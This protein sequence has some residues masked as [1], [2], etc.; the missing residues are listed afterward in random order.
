MTLYPRNSSPALDPELFRNPTSEYRGT[1]FWAWNGPLNRATL[2]RQ[3]GVLKAMGMGGYHIHVRTGLTIPYLG[4]EFMGFIRD[5]VEWAGEE[6]MLAWLYDEDR[7]PSGFAGGLV[8]RDVQY[9][10]RHLLF[11]PF[12][13]GQGETGGE[14]DSSSRVTRRTGNGALLARYSVTLKNGYLDSYH[15]LDEGDTV[16]EG[17]TTWYAYLET[18]APNPW[19]NNQT[20]VDTLNRKAI[21]RFISITHERY[22]EVVGSAFGSIIPA[23]FT[24]EPQFTHK[25]SLRFAEE[26]R[27]LVLPWTDDFLETY[28]QAYHQ[29]LEQYLPEVVW[30]L[31]G[32][33]ASLA[34]YR[35]HDHVAER[36]AQAFADTIG[37]WCNAHNLMLTGHMMEE[38]TLQ[39]QTAALGDAMRSYRGFKLPGIDMLC[40]RYEYTTAKQAQ[41]AAHQY[42]DPGVLSEL[43]GVTNWDFPFTGHKGQGDW[44][45]A[46]GVTVRVQH[47]SWVTMAG[48]AKRDYPASINEQSPWWP[49]YRFVEDHFARV[50]TALTR[51]TP[52][53]RVGVIHPVESYWLCF[54]PLNQTAIEREERESAFADLTR[55]L[56]FGL[57]DFD[58][59]AESLLPLQSMPQQSSVFQ[60]GQMAYDAVVVPPMRT[61]RST[62]LERLESFQAAGGIL[63]FAGEVP[64]LVDAGPSDRAQRLAAA[65]RQA[66]FSRGAILSALAPLRD[67]EV[68]QADGLPAQTLLYQMR[69]DG[70][71]RFVFLCNTDR[72]ES[73]LGTQIRLAG[74]WQATLLDTLTGNIEPLPT[75]YR[76][77]QTQIT[78]DFPAEGSLLLQL[79]PGRREAAERKAPAAWSEAGYLA[80]P[81]P[82]TLAEPNVLLLDQ[83]M[84][85]LDGESWAPVEEILRLDNLLRERLGWPLRMAAFAQPWSVELP[86]PTH[87]LSLR[88]DL[89]VAHPVAAPLLALEDAAK[90]SI[91]LDGQ[92]VAA[93]ISG[94]WV[95]EAIQMVPLPALRA[96][97]HAL[98]V[99]MP[100]GPRTNPEWCYLLGDF[101][102]EVLGRRARISAPVRELAFG[103]WTRQGLPF[104]AGNVIYH[105]TIEGQNAEQALHIPKFSAPL[106][107]ATLDGHRLGPIA[108]PPFQIELGRLETGRHALDITAY[109][110]RVNAFGA[111]HNSDERW[112]WFGPNAWRTTGDAWAYEYQLKPAGL[113]AAPVI[114]SKIG[115]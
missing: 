10:A 33:K 101:G 22:A 102:V 23:I 34:R 48:E 94:W 49:E 41:S 114:L 59:I 112:T 88:F 15:L 111:V 56:L 24:D 63:I 68:F 87:T 106:L 108:F 40:D 98:V 74:D 19:Y 89:D 32:G 107:A 5:A 21:E 7:W 69:T 113:L 35:Y 65:S 75:E 58:F 66:G 28:A 51:G 62:T 80:S 17:A 38:P 85:N 93:E 79:T 60:V 96:G 53:V 12:P 14:I 64:S 9:R 27:D 26:Q 3:V 100:Y 71:Q 43:Y 47:L 16:P 97:Q 109:G 39:S 110:S 92:P 86:E 13:Y 31:P 67:I 6:K 70:K 29:H 37:A 91:V 90:C 45:A 52:R 115:Q 57:I 95:D 18:A 104:Y 55:W 73:R 76:D 103:D 61:I 50:N 44:Q 72:L 54:G 4:D 36:F 1:P 30:D 81:A 105:L 84:Y 82:V 2:K 25:T 20:Y 78:W 99:S 77:G 11:T 46:L 42:G 83:A 8:T